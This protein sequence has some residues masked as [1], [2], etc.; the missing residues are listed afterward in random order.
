MILLMIVKIVVL[1]LTVNGLW[2]I[3]WLNYLVLLYY[4]LLGLHIYC[5]RY[6][7]LVY[8]IIV[9]IAG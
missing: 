6:I 7:H 2:N 5:L 9:I 3:L 8:S 4:L 1:L